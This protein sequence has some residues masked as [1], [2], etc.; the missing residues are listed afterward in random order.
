M[1][2]IRPAKLSDLDMLLALAAKV[3]TGMT[4]VSADRDVMRQR[5]EDSLQAFKRPA[6]DVEHGDSYLLVM[7]ARGKVVG[8][9]AIYTRLGKK[10]PFY[11]FRV[12]KLQYRSAS[13]GKTTEPI[14]LTL[15]N[16]FHEY[17]EIGTLFLD[18]DHRLKGRGRFLSFC[19]FMLIATD[20]HRFGKRIM[21]E[22][23]G[24]S[25]EKGRSPFWDAIGKRFFEMEFSEADR[26]SGIDNSFITDLM[27]RSPIYLPVLPHEAQSV[28]GITHAETIPARRLLEKQHFRFKDQVD[29]FDGGP[30]LE[31]H[32]ENIPLIAQA[33]A[34]KAKVSVQLSEGANSIIC[35]PNLNKFAITLGKARVNE[36][37]CI[38]I[39]S[40]TAGRIGVV[41]DDDIIMSPWTY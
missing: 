32:V 21:A 24:C 3:G 7:A 31:A 40:E 11:S 28:V 33:R 37:G 19:R 6:S 20:T 30:C 4:T 12:S 13:L 34:G 29:I 36:E 17:S 18:P 27:P 26:L 23:R 15:A 38:D 41:S 10:V 39:D 8:M 9:C 14:T 2:V 16:D 22:M 35:S 1:E 25:D 5:I